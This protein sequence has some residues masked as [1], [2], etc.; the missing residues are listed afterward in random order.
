MGRKVR[1]F[2]RRVSKALSEFRKSVGRFPTL[3]EWMKIVY[4]T[5]EG[6]VDEL[7]WENTWYRHSKWV[8]NTERFNKFW[9]RRRNKKEKT[10]KED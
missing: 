5:G 7:D 1:K 9:R 6:N 3:E 8:R 4:E 2:D 10:Q